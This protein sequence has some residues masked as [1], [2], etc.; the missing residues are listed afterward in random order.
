[1]KRMLAAALCASA[2][3]GVAHADADAAA[4]AAVRP[5]EAHLKYQDREIIALVCWGLNPYTGQEWGFG[6]V[7]PS[8]ITA[9]RRRYPASSSSRSTTTGSVSGR[10][11]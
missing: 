4:L 9:K 2:F 1:M 6:N 11:R 3:F 7:P 10:R 5:S 8:K